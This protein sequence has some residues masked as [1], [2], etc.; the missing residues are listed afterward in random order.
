M[1]PREVNLFPPCITPKR[2]W[3]FSLLP[4]LFFSYVCFPGFYFHLALHPP[5]ESL[6]SLLFYIRPLPFRFNHNII[7]WVLTHLTSCIMLFPSFLL[8]ATSFYL[9]FIMSAN[10]L[11]PLRSTFSLQYLLCDNG[12]NSV[13]YFFTVECDF[14]LFSRG[15]GGVL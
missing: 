4:C 15:L 14:K 1:I 11:L 8:Y 7:C 9:K 5:S 10:N 6:L 3:K 13:K 2:L 12:R